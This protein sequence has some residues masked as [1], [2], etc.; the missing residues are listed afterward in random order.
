MKN[1]KTFFFC[2]NVLLKYKL[3]KLKKKINQ[4]TINDLS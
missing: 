4:K 3:K 2:E 1:R